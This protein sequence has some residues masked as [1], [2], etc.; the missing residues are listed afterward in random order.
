LAPAYAPK[1]AEDNI[2]TKLTDTEKTKNSS[3]I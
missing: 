3:K 2:A 1:A